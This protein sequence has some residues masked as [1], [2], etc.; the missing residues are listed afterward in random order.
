MMDIQKNITVANFIIDQLYKDKSFVLRLNIEQRTSF[1]QIMKG[2]EI[3]LKIN[4]SWRG[5]EILIENSNVD[6]IYHVLS[7]YIAK[8]SLPESV[9]QSLKE[10]S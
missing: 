9:V 8:Y 10:V 1:F 2:T 4:H 5:C 6:Y 7:S 3:D